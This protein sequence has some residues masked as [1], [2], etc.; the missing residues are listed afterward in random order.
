MEA[1]GSLLGGYF[2]S[3]FSGICLGN[4]LLKYASKTKCDHCLY[5]LICKY[6][7]VL[8]LVDYILK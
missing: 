3:Y 5:I 1:E 8:Y 2:G 7:C 4:F 6:E